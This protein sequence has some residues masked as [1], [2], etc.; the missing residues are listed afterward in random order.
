M[1]NY[2]P[3]DSHDIV[4]NFEGGDYTPPKSNEI[5]F[6]F[7]ESGDEGQYTFPEG[8]D[9]STFGQAVI[10]SSVVTVR[11]Q[12]IGPGSFGELALQNKARLI[13]LI[14]FSHIQ[15]GR[16][17]AYNLRKYV[18]VPGILHTLFGKTYVQGGVKQV[19]PTGLN[20]SGYG[21]PTVINTRANQEV[22]PGAIP[23]ITVPQPSVSPRMLRPNGV[24][25]WS[26]GVPVVQRNP[27]PKGFVTSAYGIAW[28]SHSPRYIFPDKITAYLSG[29]PKVFDPTQ[30]IRLSGSPQMHGGIFGDISARNSRRIIVVTGENQSAYG[31]WSNVFS[32]LTNIHVSSYDTSAWGIHNIW[33]K[34]PSFAPQGL[35]STGF[36]QTLVSERHRRI[37]ARGISQFESERF[38][39]HSLWKTPEIAPKSI[40]L[41]SLGSPVV[42][43]FQR[44]IPAGGIFAQLIPNSHTVWYGLRIFKPTGLIPITPP[45]PRVEHGSRA[46][47]QKGTTH[48]AI[49]TARIWFRVRSVSV[50]SI[51][52]EFESN[53]SVGGTRFI[54]PSGFV[55][56]KFG[57][58]VI[59]ES[60]KLYP[61]GLNSFAFGESKAEL[62]K[63]IVRVPGFL[64]VGQQPGERYGTAK[65]WNKRQYITHKYDSGDGLNP[66][67]FGQWTAITN[68]NR[69]IGTFG[70]DS[71]RSGQ[72]EIHNKARL[73][74]PIG[75][76]QF[77]SEKGMIAPRIRHLRPEGM[78]SPYMGGW[79]RIVNAAAQ[80]RLLGS[81]H[82]V[83]GTASLV[84]TRREYRWIGAFESMLFGQPMVSFRIRSL[85]F[86]SRYSIA[87][88]QIPLPKLD[89]HT[90]YIDPTGFEN[91]RFGA[92]MLN[93]K[94]NLIN[95]R[96]N[97]REYFGDPAVR[98]LTPE[99]RQRGSMMED[100]G[101]PSIYLHRRD[102]KIDG[103]ISELWGRSGIAFR[104]RRITVAGFENLR[105]GLTKVVKTGAPPYSLQTITLDWAGEDQ[106][107][108]DFEGQGIQPPRMAAPQ[109]RT[110]VIFARGF[111][112][113]VVQAPKAQSNGI[114]V[115]PGI[116]EMTI[117]TPFIGLRNR[118]IEVTSLG[119]MLQ[120]AQTRPRLSPHTIYA[121]KNAP[122][123][124]IIN[125]PTDVIRYINEHVG[126]SIPPGEIFGTARIV[127]K[128]RAILAV[129]N[130]MTSIPAPTVTLRKR[131]VSVQGI[132]SFRMGWHYFLDGSPQGLE[133]YNSHDSAEFGRASLVSKYYGPQ[134]IVGRGALNSLFGNAKVEFFNRTVR[135]NGWVSMQMGTRALNDTPYKPRG[136]WVGAPMPTIPQ[137]SNA[138]VFG[139]TIVGLRVR[140]VS[141]KGF[142]SFTTEM[143]ISN[144]KGRMKVELV[145]KPVIIEPK[146]IYATSFV[147]T[148]YGVPDIRLKVHYI[149]PDGNSDQY[150]KGV[151]E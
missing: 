40:N 5:I 117:G 99:L 124:A 67:E 93:I 109:V 100:F 125:H 9:F 151:P 3:P 107:P 17:T 127:L 15:Y 29:F 23:H 131:Y 62:Y 73:V 143:D 60:R 34:T 44:Y 35:G 66:G 134:T 20:G 92:Y 63:R 61:M 57:E 144:F 14:G 2:V 25:A 101:K 72:A 133:Q 30:F 128:H 54:S 18:T 48:A 86:E 22:K 13:S 104:D 137:G 36:G 105:I 46:L 121:V 94:W 103:Y 42:S 21:R 141:V 7:R 140:D 111:D 123:Q 113:A 112:A 47:L 8:E 147:N 97:H 81:K 130:L 56:T 120:M 79:L 135:P 98:N 108:D 59:P 91:E 70:R 106:R 102:L 88:P 65:A 11:T 95:P 68:R 71:F 77:L 122:S 85:S 89:L 87:P 27:S 138:E 4:F 51:Y 45:S 28:I 146:Q 10:K 26:F 12:G 84:N 139:K 114:I 150:R 41:P 16:A 76:D 142:D 115:E 52:R 116:Q 31:D 38:G 119:D 43:N 90:R 149:R 24:L 145:K 110:N 6:D 69:E 129:G 126:T 37:Q 53:H 118:S 1:T 55:A 78:E 74:A 33:N 136:L 50:A 132:A 82:D 19:R 64:T 148:S 83:F 80:L 49:G 75:R 39:K 58:R 96:W 32:N